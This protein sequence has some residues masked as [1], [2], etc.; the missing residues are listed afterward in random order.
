MAERTGKTRKSTRKAPS[1]PTRARATGGAGKARAIDLEAECG[2]LKAEL[3]AARARIAALELQRKHL[4]DRINWA[5]D[6]LQS[7]REE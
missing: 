7:L 1:A 5:I 3:A 2:A 4:V 6:S